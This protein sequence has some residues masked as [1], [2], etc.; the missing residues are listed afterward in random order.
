MQ[1]HTCTHLLFRFPV[2]MVTN[3]SH[4]LYDACATIVVAQGHAHN[5]M[6]AGQCDVSYMLRVSRKLKIKMKLS[7][8]ITNTT[9]TKTLLMTMTTMM[10]IVLFLGDHIRIDQG[11]HYHY[12]QAGDKSN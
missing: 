5:S 11:L 6:F 1:A 7:T 3:S 10:M 8:T 2:G 4:K 12:L 9:M